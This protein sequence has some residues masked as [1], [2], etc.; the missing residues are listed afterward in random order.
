MLIVSTS[1]RSTTVSI[2][3]IL[4]SRPLKSVVGILPISTIAWSTFVSM[5]VVSTSIASTTVSIIS[6]L[7]SMPDKSVVG[8]LATSLSKSSTLAIKLSSFWSAVVKSSVANSDVIETTSKSTLS[9]CSII[10]PEALSTSPDTPS[11]IV[12]VV[13][14]SVAILE[15]S[16]ITVPI[17]SNIVCRFSVPPCNV[18]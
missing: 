8:M 17:L 3:S 13:H 11:T 12:D 6:I 16:V 7:A 15:R 14:R 2:V 10:S 4:A 18:S 1:I 5:L 9:R